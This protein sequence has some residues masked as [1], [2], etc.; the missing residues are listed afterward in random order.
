M[1]NPTI[2]QFKHCQATE[3]TFNTASGKFTIFYSYAC[4][5]L[6]IFPSG[7]AYRFT[8]ENSRKAG[9]ITWSR[10]TAK[11]CNQWRGGADYKSLPTLNLADFERQNF[12]TRLEKY[13]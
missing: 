2:R 10:T 9:A 12:D 3:A 8:F 6:V 5:E 13:Y 7:V 4:P 1:E 11:Q